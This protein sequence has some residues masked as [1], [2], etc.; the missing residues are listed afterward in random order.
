MP[1]SITAVTAEALAAYGGPQR[2]AAGAGPAGQ[3]EHARRQLVRHG[4]A[5]TVELS[6]DARAT[7]IAVQSAASGP[8]GA[9]AAQPAGPP[10]PFEP[11]GSRI[12]LTV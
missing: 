2:A 12:D 3:Y 6:A 4:G 5:V 7:L 11:P 1:T 10:R 8:P 9:P